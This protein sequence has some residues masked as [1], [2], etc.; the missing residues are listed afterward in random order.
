LG[1]AAILAAGAVAASSTALAQNALM[2]QLVVAASTD[3]APE[4][5]LVGTWKE[6]SG[7]G[8]MVAKVAA[9]GR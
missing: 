8:A 1:G 5:D 6:I 3:S 7:Q 4:I 2:E 9:K